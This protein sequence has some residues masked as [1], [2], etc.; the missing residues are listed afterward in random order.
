MAAPT[1]RRLA[2][3]FAIRRDPWWVPLLVLFGATRRRSYV[4]VDD[5]WVRVRFGFFAMRFPRERIVS[6][7]SVQGGW[8]YGI[9]WH[10]NFVSALILNG[11][12]AGLVELRLTPPEHR[13]LLLLPV[14]C[15]RLYVSLEQPDAFLRVLA[16]GG[17]L[18]RLVALD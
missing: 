16:E 2:A 9:G 18:H 1:P 4:V 15:S 5:E 6:A 14:R 3:R 8:G 11:S 10:T 7:R 12:L 17:G 13:R